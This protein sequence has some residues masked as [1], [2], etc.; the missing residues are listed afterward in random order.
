MVPSTGRS[1][2]GLTRCSGSNTLDAMCLGTEILELKKDRMKKITV[3]AVLAL[4]T[5]PAWAQENGKPEVDRPSDPPRLG[6]HKP[7]NP[8]ASPF[9]GGNGRS[10]NLTYHNGPILTT[11]TVKPIF[12]GT[13]W[14]DSTYVDDKITGL[15]KFYMGVGG[16]DYAKTNTEYTSTTSQVTA[17]VASGTPLVDSTAGPTKAPATS[18]ILSEVCKMIG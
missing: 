13:K 10:P 8:N 2:N 9:G 14:A 5:L 18:T 16:T 15:N 3:V 12:W 6:L 1:S 11:T 17:T 7:R 4:L